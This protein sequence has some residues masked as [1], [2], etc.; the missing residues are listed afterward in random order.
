MHEFWTFE[1]RSVKKLCLVRWAGRSACGS[2]TRGPDLGVW[3]WLFVRCVGANGSALRCA[4]SGIASRQFLCP[5]PAWDTTRTQSETPGER[6]RA[7]MHDIGITDKKKKHNRSD[8][9]PDPG[10]LRPHRPYAQGRT[11]AQ[12]DQV[13][14]SAPGAKSGPLRIHTKFCTG[15]TASAWYKTCRGNCGCMVQIWSAA[16]T[17]GSIL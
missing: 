10:G 13:Q 11:R 6:Q 17:A 7:V 12:Q 4:C 14:A 9:T 5:C 16:Q 8:I 3:L 1:H 2:F 15:G